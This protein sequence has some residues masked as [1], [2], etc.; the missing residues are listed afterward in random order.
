MGFVYGAV[1]SG[2]P[3]LLYLLW[4]QRKKGFLNARYE[5]YKVLFLAV[6]AVLAYVSSGLLMSVLP[7][8]HRT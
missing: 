7:V 5:L 8:R 2:L 3:P 1:M 6:V 4:L